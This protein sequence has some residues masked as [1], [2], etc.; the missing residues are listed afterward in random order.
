MNGAAHAAFI[1]RAAQE[2]LPHTVVS[3]RL[4]SECANWLTDNVE[5]EARWAFSTRT[6]RTTFCFADADEAFAFKMRWG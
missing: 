4:P 1:A 6:C 5:G 2:G 3:D